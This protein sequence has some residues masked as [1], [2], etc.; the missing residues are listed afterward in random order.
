MNLWLLFRLM[1][2]IFAR[3]KYQSS[4]WFLDS[5]QTIGTPNCR[6]FLLSIVRFRNAQRIFYI[7]NVEPK[8]YPVLPTGRQ[9]RLDN[10]HKV[11]NMF[12]TFLQNAFATYIT[13][14]VG[15]HHAATSA[16]LLYLRKL[17]SKLN[18]LR[19]SYTRGNMGQ[20]LISSWWGLP[21]YI[22]S[23]FTVLGNT[24]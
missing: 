2:S 11:R 10:F 22:R 19:Q 6:Y 7:R 17:K 3:Q 13:K 18:R 1:S 9:N 24:K 20:V 8:T 5:L 23:G 12:S 4:W 21:K 16:C 15:M 14:S